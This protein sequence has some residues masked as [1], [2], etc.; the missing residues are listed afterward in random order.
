VSTW[1]RRIKVTLY[2]PI[3]SFTGKNLKITKAMMSKI[4]VAFA[5][6]CADSNL[7]LGK[8]KKLL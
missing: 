2:G 7:N 5:C 3:L 6:Y 1:K 8:F 4:I